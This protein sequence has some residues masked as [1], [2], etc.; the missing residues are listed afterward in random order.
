MSAPKAQTTSASGSAA[1]IRARASSALTDSGWSSSRPSSRGGDRR[2]AAAVSR[3]PRPAGRS[4]RVTTSAGR[5]G[6]AARRRED[7][8]REGRGAQEGGPQA[9]LARRS[10]RVRMASLRWSRGVR[11]RIRRPSRWSISCW[12]TRASRPDGLDE[13]LLAAGVLGAD[14][15]VD[16]ALDVD[17]DAGQAQAALL[18]RLL[19]AAGP[20][21]DRVDEGVDRPVVLDAV[22]EDAG[23]EADLR[24]RQ[25]DA[26]RVVHERPICASSARR[27]SSKTSTRRACERSTGSPNC[28]HVRE[29]GVA[30]RGDLR[31]EGR[32]L[33]RLRRL[34]DLDVLDILLCHRHWRVATAGRRR[35]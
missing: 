17:V 13:D 5:C 32:R 26:E 27:A 28:A 23:Q 20:L 35:R 6:D 31:V 16:R 3:R 12:M 21:Q 7:R 22:D 19:V 33:V 9:R 8:G 25:P 11:S 30:P 18:H 4:G 15:H 2:R 10:R 1:A 34:G 24:R 14:P 29:R